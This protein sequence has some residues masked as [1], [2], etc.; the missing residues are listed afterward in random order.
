MLRLARAYPLY[1][2]CFHNLN[3]SVTDHATL[4]PGYYAAVIESKELYFVRSYFLRLSPG[5]CL[6]L[7]SPTWTYIALWVILSMNASGDISLPRYE[8]QPLLLVPVRKMLNASSRLS[9]ATDGATVLQ[10]APSSLSKLLASISRK[11]RCVTEGTATL[12]S[13]DL[14]E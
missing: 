14:S 5:I 13:E 11:S 8:R 4:L 7:V 6:T 9:N 12:P 1:A 3:H 2:A 10:P